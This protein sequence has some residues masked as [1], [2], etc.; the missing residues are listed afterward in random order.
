M[1]SKVA[2]FLNKLNTMK[3]N[4]KIICFFNADKNK[5]IEENYLKTF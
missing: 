2:P 1:K 5:T 4:V 3:K